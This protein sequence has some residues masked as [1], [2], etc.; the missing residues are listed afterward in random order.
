MDAKEGLGQAAATVRNAERHA[1]PWIETLARVGYAAK[2]VVYI[3]I[4]VIAARVAFGEG[5]DVEG[6][7][8]AIRSL[9]DEPFGTTMLWLMGLGLVGYVVWRLV[10][11]IRN[12][13]NEKKGKRVFYVVSA[14]VYGALALEALRLATGSGGGGETHWT[15]ALLAQPF[16][17]VLAAIAGLAIA[18]YGIQQLWRG[19]TSDLDRRLDLSSL[20]ATYRT[21]VRRLGRFGLAARGVVLVILGY[22]FLRAALDA[23]SSESGDVEGV[24]GSMTDTPWLLA[25]IGLGFVA[26]G[27]YNVVLA[28]YRRIRAA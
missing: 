17:R 26:Y 9:R 23:Q 8:G 16:G 24:L 1:A 3:L 25:V 18:G 14:L 20:S 27:A 6:G 11:A 2:G 7:S 22:I 4:G 10:A 28:R 13:E 12:P 5:G 15:S 21:W 19:W